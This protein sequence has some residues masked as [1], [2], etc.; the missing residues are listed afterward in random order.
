MAT[1]RGNGGCP[2]RSAACGVPRHDPAARMYEKANLKRKANTHRQRGGVLRLP[3]LGGR[4]IGLL[5]S[6]V[7]GERRNG[8]TR[9]RGLVL[10]GMDDPYPAATPRTLR[11]STDTSTPVQVKKESADAGGE[12]TYGPC[13]TGPTAG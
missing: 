13:S 6:R 2:P 7:N 10:R 8:G 5:K 12:R 4:N 11:W 3:R 9:T 1:G